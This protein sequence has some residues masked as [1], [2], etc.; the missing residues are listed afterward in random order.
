MLIQKQFQFVPNYV[1]FFLMIKLNYL[2]QL[3]KSLYVPHN[4][5]F[6]SLQRIHFVSDPCTLVVNNVSIG[7]SSMDVLLHLGSEETVW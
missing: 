3:Q 5:S 2:Q 6:Y 4:H 7:L 1:R